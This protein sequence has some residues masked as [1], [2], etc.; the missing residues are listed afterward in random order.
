MGKLINFCS[1]HLGLPL[2]AAEPAAEP[3][4]VGSGRKAASG[5]LQPGRAEGAR[6]RALELEL[7]YLLRTRESE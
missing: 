4:R 7:G 6:K 5:S 1:P 2:E 3:F